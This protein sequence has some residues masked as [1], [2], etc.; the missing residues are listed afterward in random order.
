MTRN[1]C[2]I[3]TALRTATLVAGLLVPASLR[4]AGDEAGAR[5]LFLEARKLAA[6]GDYAAACPKFEDSYRLDPGIGTN[7][8]L[9]DCYEHS[10]RIASAWARFLDVAAATKA[11]GQTDRER[12]AR[13]RAGALEPKLVRMTLQVEAQAPG[14]AVVRDGI[15][16]GA[17]AWRVAVPVDPGPHV[18][19]ASAPGRVAWKITV[20]VKEGPGAVTV[21]VPDLLEAPP[22]P[23][24]GPAA[25]PTLTGTQTSESVLVAT[26]EAP[27]RRWSRPVVILGAIGAAALVTGAAFGIEFEIDNGKAEAIS[28]AGGTTNCT[29]EQVTNHGDLVASANT[30]LKL[31][32]VGLA[33]GGAA[34]LTA[35]YLWWREVRH[36]RS[37]P[38]SRPALAAMPF[39]PLGLTLGGNW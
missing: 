37:G 25:S 1:S 38:A 36:E 9:A 28:C 11:A 15:A 39:G 17:A 14:V 23:I 22:E 24:V 4:A 29:T 13:A 31:E 27:H 32:V 35:G 18:I 12:V 26:P 3:S 20:A 2:A 6:A 30:D 7:F 33:V 10:G 8:N 34:L 19:E 16:V 5:V 21:V